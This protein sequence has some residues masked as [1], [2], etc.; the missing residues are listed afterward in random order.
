M[1]GTS[2]FLCVLCV[3]LTLETYTVLTATGACVLSFCIN[4]CVAS[5]VSGVC[6][7]IWVSRS[8][9]MCCARML[10]VLHA[11]V[12]A[13]SSVYVLCAYAVCIVR[14]CCKRVRRASTQVAGR[15]PSPTSMLE[16]HVRMS[17]VLFSNPAG[18]G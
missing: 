9:C 14:V 17:S 15:C 13:D 12:G 2:S 10:Y 4:A 3:E 8:A 18:P 1:G 5:M 11:R 16:A 7:R 6:A